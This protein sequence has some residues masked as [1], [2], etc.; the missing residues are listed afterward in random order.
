MTAE[1]ENTLNGVLAGLQLPAVAADKEL[2]HLT[3]DSRK[4]TGGE[5]FI[6]VPGLQSDGRKYIA[7]AL[8]KGAAAVLVDEDEDFD[9][10]SVADHES[11]FMVP[12]LREKVGVLANRFYRQPSEQLK[13]IGVTGTNGKTSCCWFISEILRQLGEPCSLMGTVGRGLPGQMEAS[14]KYNQ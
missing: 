14:F 3:L 11:V 13:V 12:D 10:L 7:D 9:P 8:S 5:L 6:A 1:K 2:N 4:I